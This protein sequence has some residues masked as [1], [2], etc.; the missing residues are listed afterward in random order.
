MKFIT[1]K[2]ERMRIVLDTEMATMKFLQNVWTKEP[3][4]GDSCSTGA[5]RRMLGRLNTGGTG[6]GAAVALCYS[7]LVLPV[8]YLVLQFS[9][10][11]WNYSGVLNSPLHA[12]W[13]Y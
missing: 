12:S 3:L 11:P 10:K 5:G 8:Y 2:C 7:V 6:F 9:A 1:E 4:P 13:F